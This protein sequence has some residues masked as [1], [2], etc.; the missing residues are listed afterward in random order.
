MERIY[1]LE[2][3]PDEL[4]KLGPIYSAKETRLVL[5]SEFKPGAPEHLLI[6]R[7]VISNRLERLH[8]TGTREA[9]KAPEIKQVDE[10]QALHLQNRYLRAGTQPT[11]RVEIHYALRN[12]P[13]SLTLYRKPEGLALVTLPE[14]ST[15][16]ASDFTGLLAISREVTGDNRFTL[17]GIAKGLHIRAGAPAENMQAGGKSAGDNSAPQRKPEVR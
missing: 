5:L 15:L 2:S 3:P 8:V 4:Q 1:L 6:E 10:G 14:S 7:D 11:E 13:F 12:Q 16:Q 9:G 17:E